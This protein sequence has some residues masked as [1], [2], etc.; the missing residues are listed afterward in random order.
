MSRAVLSLGSNLGDRRAHLQTAV[1]SLRRAVRAVSAIYRTPPWG[2]VAQDDF[3]NIIV[4]AE[5]D[6]VDA[7]GWLDHCQALEQAAGRER[8]VRWGPRTLDAD[9]IAVD[10]HGHPVVSDDPELTL[11]HPRAAERAFVL[12]P[13]AEVDPTAEL[14]GAGPIADLLDGIDITGISRVGHVH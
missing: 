5:D 8:L 1:A 14:P 4:L 9:V 6:T 11:P 3:Y 12:L 13:W 2:G 10:L 7:R